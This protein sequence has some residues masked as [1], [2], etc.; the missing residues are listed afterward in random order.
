[1]MIVEQRHVFRPP[2]G[3]GGPI[4]IVGMQEY[5]PGQ[6][7]KATR[8]SLGVPKEYRDRIPDRTECSSYGEVRRT[9]ARCFFDGDEKQVTLTQTR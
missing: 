8:W 5:S 6:T 4:V 1:M 7:S 2:D 3:L 9:L